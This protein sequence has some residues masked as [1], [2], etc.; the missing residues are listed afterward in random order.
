MPASHAD[1]GAPYRVF[2]PNEG[3]LAC[4]LRSALHEQTT[5]DDQTIRVRGER[6][7]PCSG[8]TVT[9]RDRE[10]LLAALD[11]AILDRWDAELTPTPL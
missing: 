2:F 9:C 1:C 5:D 3:H 11:G 8:L 10:C 6:R 4:M 7:S